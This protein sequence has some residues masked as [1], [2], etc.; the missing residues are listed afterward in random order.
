MTPFQLRVTDVGT[1]VTNLH[2]QVIVT[3]TDKVRVLDPQDHVEADVEINH[4]EKGSRF[5]FAIEVDPVQLPMLQLDFR[6]RWP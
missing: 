3:D 6:L 2:F 5:L 1:S 4:G